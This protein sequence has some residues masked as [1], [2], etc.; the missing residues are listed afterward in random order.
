M[1]HINSQ[2]LEIPTNLMYQYLQMEERYYE[3]DNNGI[4]EVCDTNTNKMCLAAAIHDCV[5]NITDYAK[6]WKEPNTVEKNTAMQMMNPFNTV[7]QSIS[8]DCATNLLSDSNYSPEVQLFKF[9][10]YKYVG[11]DGSLAVQSNC[12]ITDWVNEM[13]KHVGELKNNQ[14]KRKQKGDRMLYK[15]Q[16]LVN[17]MLSTWGGA[18]YCIRMDLGF[19][20]E[21]GISHNMQQAIE[22][23]TEFLKHARDNDIFPDG[24]KYIWFLDFHHQKGYYHHLYI[25]CDPHYVQNQELFADNIGKFW[26]EKITN[27]VGNYIACHRL[28][29]YKSHRKAGVGILLRSNSASMQA[30]YFGFSFMC[31][32][33]YYQTRPEFFATK[34]FDTGTFRNRKRVLAS[35][36]NILDY[37]FSNR[38]QYFGMAPALQVGQAMS[39]SLPIMNI[40]FSSSQF[41]PLP[42]FVITICLGF[43]NYTNNPTCWVPSML[44]NGF[45]LVTGQSGAGKT[46]SLKVLCSTLSCLNVPVW[47]FDPHNDLNDLGFSTILLSGGSEGSEGINPLNLCFTDFSRRGMHDHI[48]TKVDMICRA[49]KRLGHRGEDML[50]QALKEAY[51]RRGFSMDEP[52]PE[53]KPPTFQLV[54]DIL[55]E[56]LNQDERKNSHKAIE[57]ALSALRLI[58]SYPLFNRSESFDVEKHLKSSIHFD[59]SAL[60]ESV[61]FVVVESLLR[62]VFSYFTQLGPIPKS[63]VDDYERFRLF[64]AIDETKLLTMTGKDPEAADRILNILVSEGRKFGIGLILVSQR[65]EHFSQE[66][67]TNAAAKLVH[68]TQDAK[69]AKILADQMQVSPKALMTLSGE[70]DG[71]FS[72]G[73]SRPS[74]INVF[75]YKP[76][77]SESDSGKV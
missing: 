46:N 29:D 30:F 58:F 35:N 9:A 17:E 19:N 10:F 67:R 52:S 43:D 75:P 25:F 70:G 72:A 71:F 34:T 69:E 38:N 77:K 64:I 3:Y 44:N 45:I 48:R 12:L 55:E 21:S 26:K 27:G 13:I 28:G 76:R 1:S 16:T 47:V 42:P 18:L 59:L 50:Q 61:R 49:A 40:D 11:L 23:R 39:N 20:L 7:Y 6:G 66:I 53:C 73:S 32:R 24:A 5:S 62:Q 31:Q 2:A 57:S 33:E 60:N 51:I 68:K 63:P 14:R 15:G 8:I 37:D 56:W 65:T 74:K 4:L 36:S 54:I 41:N 22:Y